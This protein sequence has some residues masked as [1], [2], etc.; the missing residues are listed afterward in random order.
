MAKIA[1]NLALKCLHILVLYVYVTS[2]VLAARVL[3]VHPYLQSNEKRISNIFDTSKYGI[4]Q[5]KNGL[6]DTPQM[7]WNSWN[8][9]ACNIN[10][11]V[12]KETGNPLTLLCWFCFVN[13]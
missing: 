8:F 11:T 6:A 13:G 5:I 7:G 1:G 9:F 12:I 10:E 4:L 3:P 2:V